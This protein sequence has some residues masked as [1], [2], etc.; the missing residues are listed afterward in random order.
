MAIGQQFLSAKRISTPCRNGKRLNGKTHPECPNL[1]ELTPFVN[2]CG[3]HDDVSRR[4]KAALRSR[5]RVRRRLT[6]A[7]G[8]LHL[9]PR[10]G[11]GFPPCPGSAAAF[12]PRRPPAAQTARAEKGMHSL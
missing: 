1:R 3:R 10:P 8:P 12:F 4:V 2:P 6:A 7:G 5:G 11:D 9:W